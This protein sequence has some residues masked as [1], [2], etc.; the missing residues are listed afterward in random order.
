MAVGVELLATRSA[1]KARGPALCEF[2]ETVNTEVFEILAA[3]GKVFK[4]LTP[5]AKDVERSP[6]ATSPVVVFIVEDFD[7]VEASLPPPTSLGEL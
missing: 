5:P 3:G 2:F 6:P 7:K 1:A 4:T